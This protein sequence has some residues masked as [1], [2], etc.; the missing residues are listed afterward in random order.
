[1]KVLVFLVVCL[2]IVFSEAISKPGDYR[3]YCCDRCNQNVRASLKNNSC[4]TL[5]ELVERKAQ[6]IGQTCHFDTEMS[7]E[8][9]LQLKINA[10]SN[11][12]MECVPNNRVYRNVHMTLDSLHSIFA[13]FP[14]PI[15]VLQ[16]IKGAQDYMDEHFEVLQAELNTPGFKVPPSLRT[17]IDDFFKDNVKKAVEV[18]EF[19]YQNAKDN[20]KIFKDPL[21]RSLVDE[22]MDKMDHCLGIKS[23]AFES[24]FNCRREVRSMTE[25]LDRKVEELRP[26]VRVKP[27]PGNQ[28]IDL[29]LNNFTDELKGLQWMIM[30]EKIK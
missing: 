12:A 1:M 17:R 3:K 19:N 18:F 6:E 23:T 27:I 26:M 21:M 15:N 29:L 28:S 7:P 20:L 11:A 30:N 5:K 16:Q 14:S 8:L 9:G 22:L 13:N 4:V 24:I 25:G 2:L 10:F